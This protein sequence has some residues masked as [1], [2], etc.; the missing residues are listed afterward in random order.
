MKQGY[1]YLSQNDC[2]AKCHMKV[3]L[4]YVLFLVDMSSILMKN[5]L[6]SEDIKKCSNVLLFGILNSENMLDFYLLE[7]H[8]DLGKF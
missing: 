3:G 8:E 4:P 1:G 6:S 2:I 5:N 7:K